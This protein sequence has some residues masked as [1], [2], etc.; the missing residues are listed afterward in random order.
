M[1]HN[2]IYNYYFISISFKRFCRT[3]TLF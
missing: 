3:S 1:Q 2:N